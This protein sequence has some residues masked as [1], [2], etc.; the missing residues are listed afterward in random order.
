M[1]NSKQHGNTFSRTRFKCLTQS[2]FIRMHFFFSPLRTEIGSKRQNSLEVSI[3]ECENFTTQN[4]GKLIEILREKIT[5]NQKK[6]E[7][8]LRLNPTL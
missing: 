3:F 1:T 8:I 4:K 7:E 5:K 6:C 2:T